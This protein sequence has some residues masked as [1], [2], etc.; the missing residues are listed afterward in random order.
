MVGDTKQHLEILVHV[1]L[2]SYPIHKNYNLKIIGSR[3]AMYGKRPK[4]T[5]L[6][7][8]LYSKNHNHRQNNCKEGVL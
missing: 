8:Y 3:K 4:F 2:H 7:I 6:C 5:H 1:G